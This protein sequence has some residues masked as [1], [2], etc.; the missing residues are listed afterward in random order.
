MKAFERGFP[1]WSI[2]TI[3]RHPAEHQGV[4]ASEPYPLQWG[5]FSTLQE[6]DV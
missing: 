4:S 3:A 6:L 5:G 1:G 2:C